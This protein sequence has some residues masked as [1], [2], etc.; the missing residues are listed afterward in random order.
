MS[1]STCNIMSNTYNLNFIKEGHLFVS[2][3]LAESEHHQQI[4]I[5]QSWNFIISSFLL[6]LFCKYLGCEGWCKKS[7]ESEK[8]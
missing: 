8:F 5:K 2:T 6:L 4:K 3:C 1:T 7:T